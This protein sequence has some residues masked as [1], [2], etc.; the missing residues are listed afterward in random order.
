VSRSDRWPTRARELERPKKHDAGP[1]GPASAM[2]SRL[3]GLLVTLTYAPGSPQ[4]TGGDGG[5]A[6]ANA[7]AAWAV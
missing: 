7:Y 2:D 1:W 4:S 6:G 3:Y 5:A